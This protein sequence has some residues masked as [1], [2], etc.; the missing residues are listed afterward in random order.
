MGF[1]CFAA[2]A[3][4]LNQSDHNFAKKVVERDLREVLE[5]LCRTASVNMFDAVVGVVGQ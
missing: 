3:N 5:N 4:F 1:V 2:S